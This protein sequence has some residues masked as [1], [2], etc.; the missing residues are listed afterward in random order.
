M[1]ISKGEFKT[2]YSHLQNLSKSELEN[3]INQIN[4]GFTSN[5]E[6]NNI[7]QTHSSAK[8][9]KLAN[10]INNFMFGG[11]ETSEDSDD[12]QDEKDT[13]KN[14]KDKTKQTDKNAK[15]ADK[16]TKP[17][18]APGVVKAPQ[19]T[20]SLDVSIIREN[21]REILEK[22]KI[23]TNILKEKE[24]QLALS[25][26][27]ERENFMKEIKEKEEKVKKLE[28]EILELEKRKKQLTTEITNMNEA[29]IAA[30]ETIS[31]IKEDIN[32]L[33]G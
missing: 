19:N 26:I 7:I 9:L 8:V 29:K 13:K 33:Q 23:K 14:S 30:K 31:K 20:Q 24:T 15:P 18:A 32:S 27:K 17:N 1:K 22:L 2:I 21:T 10:K 3:L 4:E 5:D 11:A 12:E 16:N 6:I 28:N 25:I